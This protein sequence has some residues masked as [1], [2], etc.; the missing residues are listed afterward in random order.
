MSVVRHG[1][2]GDSGFGAIRLFSL[3]TGVSNVPLEASRRGGVAATVVASVIGVV[4]RDDCS[5]V[6]E[7]ASFRSLIISPSSSIYKHLDD[8]ST[9][10]EAPAT[11]IQSNSYR[12]RLCRRSDLTMS[13]AFRL[14][15]FVG[16]NVGDDAVTIV[17]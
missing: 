5:L 3:R 13:D 14:H 17:I 11:R 16:M 7:D 2:F 4:A 12:S 15:F 6:G 10:F 9:G 8:F 1:L